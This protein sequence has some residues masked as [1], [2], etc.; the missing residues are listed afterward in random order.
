MKAT[1]LA[2]VMALNPGSHAAAQESPEADNLD[3]LPAPERLV[4]SGRLQAERSG[5][6]RDFD[7]IGKIRITHRLYQDYALYIDGKYRG[8]IPVD[9][10]LKVGDHTFEVLV[11]PGDRLPFEHAIEFH[12]NVQ[13]LHLGDGVSFK[14]AKIGP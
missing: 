5:A 9:A 13:M 3:D 1:L 14:P 6:Y 12:P 2:V 8:R 4:K 10:V 11:G 7:Q